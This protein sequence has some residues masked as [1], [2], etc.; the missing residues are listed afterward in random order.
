MNSGI[1]EA[2]GRDSR[3]LVKYEVNEV[4]WDLQGSYREG[5]LSGSVATEL[6]LLVSA[7]TL[8]IRELDFNP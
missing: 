1:R 8:R 4:K 6:N 5:N 2:R 3:S 7:P